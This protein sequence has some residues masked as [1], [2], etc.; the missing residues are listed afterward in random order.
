MTYQQPA[1]KPSGSPVLRAIGTFFRFLIRLL[2]ILIVGALVGVG[3]YYG[4]PWAYRTLV[5][6]VQQNTARVA[7]LEQRMAQ[8]QNRLQDENLALQE[9]IAALEV[10]ITTLREESAVQSQEVEGTVERIQQ[11]EH[12]IT[13]AEEDLEAQQKV[14]EAMHSELDSAI[15]D[16]GEQ[17]GQVAGRT[18]GLEGRL[19]VLQ[20][21]QDLL[22]VRLLLLEE[23]SRSAR[24]T[25]ALA[26]VHLEQA[27]A[28]MPEQADT[29]LGLQTR[30]A[31]LE[32]LIA[33]RSFR[34]GP[35]LESIWA[36]VMD[37]VLPSI[38]PPAGEPIPEVP[39]EPT[40]TPTP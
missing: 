1:S 23:N 27:A 30:M 40:P 12:R 33:E 4:V 22:K 32:R 15:A 38:L 31:G 17:T 29:L 8:E 21:A 7:A 13:Q 39:A 19:A 20:T 3:L 24:D 25:L 5:Q 37:L 35:E 34:A 11:L 36:D 14:V 26:R 18:E 9:R 16:L 10:K 28:L 2:F 6:P